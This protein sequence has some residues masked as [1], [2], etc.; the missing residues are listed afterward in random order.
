VLVAVEGPRGHARVRFELDVA[1]PSTPSPGL[2]PW[3]LWPIPVIA[4]YATH[5]RLVQSKDRSRTRT[6]RRASGADAESVSSGC[7]D[8]S[9]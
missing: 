6:R 1:R 4:I 2:W 3:I 7:D 9:Q 5:R 8:T